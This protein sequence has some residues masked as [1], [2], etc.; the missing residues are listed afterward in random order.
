MLIHK[1]IFIVLL[2]ATFIILPLNAFSAS[3][4]RKLEV[5]IPGLT[6]T[7]IPV[8]SVYIVAIYNF[9][10]TAIGVIALGALVYGGFRYVASAGNP[11]AL[12]DA[13]DQMS[14][15][16]LGLILLF[17][18]WLILNTIN[19]ELVLLGEPQAYQHS[20]TNKTDCT[21]Q[22]CINGRCNMTYVTCAD[23]PACIANT[24]AWV[25]NQE[26]I[27]GTNGKGFC[28]EKPSVISFWE[29]DN[30]EGNSFSAEEKN[31]KAEPGRI[32][33]LGA[34]NWDTAAT[35]VNDLISSIKIND[36]SYAVILFE[37]IDYNNNYSTFAKVRLIE[38]TTESLGLDWNDKTSSY[39]IVKKVGTSRKVTL[40]EHIDYNAG[41]LPENIKCQDFPFFNSNS[42]FRQLPCSDGNFDNRASSMKVD[43]DVLAILYE[44]ADFEGRAA[45]FGASNDYKN[46]QFINPAVND[47]FSSIQVINAVGQ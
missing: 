23:T 20:C 47:Q 21:E 11:T 18:S 29:H 7:C 25:K 4:C 3:P 27:E 5:Q 33:N 15:A 17:C 45:F 2:F 10:L 31:Y 38:N 39:I 36:P 16:L 32:A 22:K 34:V 43:Y 9:A 6:T 42:D 30:F 24:P 8:L 41:A 1:K 12:S 19:P 44:D 46:F 13:K 37:D 14:S 35:P 28:A 26:C 40:Y